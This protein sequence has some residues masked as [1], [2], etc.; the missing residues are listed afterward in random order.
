MS[1]TTTKCNGAHLAM[2]INIYLRIKQS[3]NHKFFGIIKHVNLKNR[4]RKF[5][6][7]FMHFINFYHRESLQIKKQGNAFY[8]WGNT[9]AITVQF[10][11][12]TFWDK[13]NF[14]LYNQP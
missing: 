1:E 9:C 5:K 14:M 11:H 10:L 6:K 3:D 12:G 13:Y 2:Y 8:L 7:Y 4:I